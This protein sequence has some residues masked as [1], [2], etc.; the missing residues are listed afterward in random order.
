MDITLTPIRPPIVIPAAGGNFQFTAQ[1]VNTG[2]TPVTFSVWIMQY[3]PGLVWQGPMLGPLSLTIPGGLTVTRNRAQNVPGSTAPGLYTYRGYV[4]VY[5]GTKW[6]SSSFQYTKSTTGEGPLVTNWE[7]YGDS[8][9]PFLTPVALSDLPQVYSLAQ[10]H[11]NPFNPTTT[12]SYGLPQAAQVN[13]KVYDLQGRLI[14]E[15]VNGMK[16]AGVHYVTFDGSRLASG[17]Y[18]YRLQADDF[19]AVKKMMLVK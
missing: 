2:A 1:L 12:I 13:L 6:D 5:P 18:F 3:T 8:F 19:S 4:G 9:E 17:M 7:N 14:A 16:D 10:C 15:L 11:P